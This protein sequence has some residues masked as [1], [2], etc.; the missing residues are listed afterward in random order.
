MIDSASAAASFCEERLAHRVA[1]GSTGGVERRTE[2]V[3]LASGFEVRTT[4]W[5]HGRRRYLVGGGVRTLAEAQAL[6]AF[7]EARRGRLIGF[8][9]R[10]FADD[11]SS[12][13]GAGIGPLDQTIGAGDGQTT[14]FAL[15]K[16]YG[17]PGGY[18]RPIRKPVAGT[19]LAAVD[20][21]PVSGFT[22]DP[23]T[24]LVR[25]D[26]APAAGAVVTSGFLFDTP[27]RF[28]VDRLDVTL[29]D[30]EAARVGAFALIEVRV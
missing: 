16:A 7:F 11:R 2:I 15:V 25:F 3:T 28:D 24:G 22:A 1:F 20:G 30:F 29:Q 17:G 27:V 19:V 6:V 12:A 4:P 14:D 13:P 8:R 23:T 5:M 21:R 10:D 18:L 26:A 9:F